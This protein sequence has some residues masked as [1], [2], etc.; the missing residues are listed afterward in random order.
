MALNDPSETRTKESNMPA[1]VRWKTRARN[2]SE[3]LDLCRG[4]TDAGPDLL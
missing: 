3:S 2:E 4:G 1:S